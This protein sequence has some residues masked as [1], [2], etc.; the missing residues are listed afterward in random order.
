MI[1]IKQTKYIYNTITLIKSSKK[2]LY[3]QSYS[4]YSKPDYVYML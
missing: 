3:G 4:L 2:L 1:T